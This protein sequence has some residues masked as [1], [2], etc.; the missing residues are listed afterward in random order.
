VVAQPTQSGFLAWVRSAMGITTAELPDTSVF[1]GYA[2]DVALEIVNPAL[3]V[4]S[5]L[6]YTLAVYNLGGDNLIN[7]AQDVPP[8]TFF[9]DARKSFG[10]GNFVAGVVTNSSDNGTSSGLTTPEAFKMF[11]LGNLQNLKT[12]YGRQYLA[13]AQDYGT[14]WGLS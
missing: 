9:T 4:A 2:Y 3:Q 1:I 5:P 12:P 10:I 6:I 14:L 11:T 8:S 7:F 13:F